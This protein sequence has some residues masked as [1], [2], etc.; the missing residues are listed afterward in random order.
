M[1]DRFEQQKRNVISAFT[2]V[3]R[4]S[5]LAGAIDVQRLTFALDQLLTHTGPGQPLDLTSFAAL[6]CEMN[7]SADDA[8]ELLV[9]LGSRLEAMGVIAVMPPEV[10]GL[11]PARRQWL[12]DRYAKR[13]AE[14]VA[15]ISR[16][17]TPAPGPAVDKKGAKT[18]GETAK[19]PAG[20]PPALGG[21]VNMKLVGA[22]VAI[23]AVGLGVY[24]Y[25]EQTAPPPLQPVF[26]TA[27]GGLPCQ[28]IVGKEQIAIC[29]MPKATFEGL[30][31][32]ALH[33]KGKATL[34]ALK[35][36]GFRMV[37]VQILEDNRFRATF[38]TADR[39]H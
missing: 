4:T 18:K 14:R 19:R 22:L 25:G 24:I 17:M 33:K 16:P 29:R 39:L 27:T 38:H 3:A 12:L 28:E 2:S 10:A 30:D 15:E 36:Q 8:A 34:E 35:S 23:I 1:S 37:H 13:Q 32:R 5:A 11:P 31:E 9:V 6:L 20:F 7:A 26:I 21:G